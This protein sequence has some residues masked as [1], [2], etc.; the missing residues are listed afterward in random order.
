MLKH[1]NGQPR[2][3]ANQVVAITEN[4]R[5]CPPGGDCPTFG[6]SSAVD[7]VLE[8]PAGSVATWGLRPGDTIVLE[9]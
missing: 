1:R 5:P 2:P 8:V 9:R 4:A 7:W 6:P 3:L